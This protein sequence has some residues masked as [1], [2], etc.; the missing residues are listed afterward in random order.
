MARLTPLHEAS[1]DAVEQ[2]LDDAFGRDRHGRTAYRLR[3]G[4][5]PDA[6]LSFAAFE[7]EALV[8]TLQS[9]PIALVGADGEGTPLVL[10]GPVAVAPGRQGTGIGRAMMHAMLAAADAGQEPALTLIGDPDYYGRLFGFTAVATGGWTLPGPWE[11]HRLLARI[12]P[13]IALPAAGR[14]APA[15]ALSPAES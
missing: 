12:R 7:G 6:A 1:H 9:W 2:L 14:L 4:A 3:I 8:G 13:G 5:E 15:R 11:P 10:V